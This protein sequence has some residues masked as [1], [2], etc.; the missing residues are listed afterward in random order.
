MKT[1]I[2]AK[3]TANGFELHFTYDREREYMYRNMEQ[4]ATR[5]YR[6]NPAIITHWRNA[7]QPGIAYQGIDHDKTIRT[8]TTITNVLVYRWG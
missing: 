2:G 7:G 6:R 5:H 1:V 4:Q 8:D 3:T